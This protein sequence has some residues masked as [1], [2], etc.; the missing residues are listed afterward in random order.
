MLHIAFHELMG[1]A[2]QQVL[3]C[4]LRGRM[5]HGH[6]V[7]QLVT[8]AVGAARLVK[9]ATCQEA[10]GNDLVQQPAVEHQIHCGLRCFYVHLAKG[11]AP[12]LAYG[13][14]GCLGRAR[15]EGVVQKAFGGFG[16]LLGTQAEHQLA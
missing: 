11:F 6:A 5:Q 14:Q 2:Q 7:L 1:R 13:L 9:T 8:E 10:R 12:V 4:A 15:S 3:A 16:V